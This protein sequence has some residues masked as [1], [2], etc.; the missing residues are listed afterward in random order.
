MPAVAAAESRHCRN[1]AFVRGISLK[2]LRCAVRLFAFC[3]RKIAVIIRQFNFLA[4]MADN[5]IH[6][7]NYRHT[8]FF[9]QRISA[10][11]KFKAF[12][13][14][15]RSK[16]NQPVVAVG[17]PACLHNIALGRAGRL[18]GRRAHTLHVNNYQRNFRSAGITDK[19]LL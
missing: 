2:V 8:V 14:A 18:A 12:G 15:C 19:L 17:A 4:H 6:Q 5:F 7:K 16:G 3:L 10:Q 9:A 11:S 1:K 13:N